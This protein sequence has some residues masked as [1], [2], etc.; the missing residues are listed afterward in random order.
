MIVL[1]NRAHTRKVKHTDIVVIE[2]YLPSEA[3][4][5][6]D[7]YP[8]NDKAAPTAAV[9]KREAPAGGHRFHTE[10]FAQCNTCDAKVTPWLDFGDDRRMK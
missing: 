3:F 5:S 6:P 2:N 1:H 7:I 8:R 9:L 4:I 10:C